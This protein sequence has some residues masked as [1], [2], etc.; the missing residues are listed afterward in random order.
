MS[1]V[2]IQETAQEG[3]Y[4]LDN[5]HKFSPFVEEAKQF[6][7]SE[8]A[9]QQ[10]EYWN[11]YWQENKHPYFVGKMSGNFVIVILPY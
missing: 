7:F 3:Y 9:E 2:V 4:Y 10:A 8:E 1:Y 6:E 11:K 5:N